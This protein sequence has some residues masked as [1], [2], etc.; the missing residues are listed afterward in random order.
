[1]A[2]LHWLEN[3]LSWVL[4]QKQIKPFNFF[5]AQGAKANKVVGDCWMDLP[6]LVTVEFSIV[7]MF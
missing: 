5:V 4:G 7:I 6:Y 1:V 2:N 3:A